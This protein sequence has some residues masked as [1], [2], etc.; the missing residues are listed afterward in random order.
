MWLI[1]GGNGQ[2]GKAFAVALEQC[3]IP[4]QS[5]SSADLD[6][7]SPQ[8]TFQFIVALK[9]A[10][11]VNCAAWTDVDAAESDFEGAYAVNALGALNLSRGAK[12]VNAIFAHISTD[13]VF[14]GLNSSP[15]R[16]DDQQAPVSVYGKTK[17]KGE[18]LVLSEYWERS[19]VFRTAW[20]YSKWGKNFAK[21]MVR[22]ALSSDADV[23]VVD[24][25]V[26][27]PTSALDLAYQI[28]E[29]I[30]AQLPFGIYHGTNSGSAS[31]FKFAQEVFRLC[32]GEVLKN[33]V[34]PTDSSAFTRPAKR[35]AYS[36]LGHESWNLVGASNLLVPEMRDW[37]IA[38]AE[39]VPSI[40][41]TVREEILA[42]E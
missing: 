20:L 40:I 29:T 32:G 23:K 24:D 35:P 17:A 1:L 7:R 3:G 18:L 13:Y 27:Q 5:C 22:L 25:Q 39:T 33:R 4:F 11:V 36:V 9:P 31:W 21:T 37:K 8:L 14:S 26:G 6:I 34:V 10:V 38:L 15:W 30:N 41:S 19:Y 28:I 12:A 2:L 42:S 16:E